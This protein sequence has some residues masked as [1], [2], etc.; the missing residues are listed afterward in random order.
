M[1]LHPRHGLNPSVEKCFFCGD[2]KGVV[3][4]GASC[5]EEA[6]RSVVINHEPCKNC[7]DM[8]RQGTMLIEC[9]DGEKGDNPY[10][11]GRLWVVKDEAAKRMKIEGKIAFI[12]ES[13]AKHMGFHDAEAA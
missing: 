12:E 3:L 6:P 11:T 2:D 4:F 13:M 7:Q 9:R 10:R 1:R 8:L 5:K